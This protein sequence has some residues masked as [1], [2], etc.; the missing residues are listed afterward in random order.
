MFTGWTNQMTSWIGAKKTQSPS[1]PGSA[2]PSNAEGQ[3]PEN[4]TP[5]SNEGEAASVVADGEQ[6]NKG[7]ELFNSMKSQMTNWS[8]GFGPLSKGKETKEKEEESAAADQTEE[9]TESAA[10]ETAKPVEEGTEG[11]EDKDKETFGS[12]LEE[13]STKALQG[14]KTFGNFF[15]SAVSKAGKTVTEAGAKIKKTVEETSLLTEFNKEQEAFI[16]SKNKAGEALPP[17]VG[18]PEEDALMKKFFPFQRIGAI[19]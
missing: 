13:V 2:S 17:W 14:A 7:I 8:F 9:P 11:E 19:S 5:T 1:E 15:V 3:L 12:G 4:T 16:K 10:A 6:Q 18:Y